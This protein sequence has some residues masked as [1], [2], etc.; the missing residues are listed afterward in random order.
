MW[1]RRLLMLSLLVRKRPLLL[2]EV[3]LALLCRVGL[4]AVISFVLSVRHPWQL[5]SCRA[6]VCAFVA[7]G[8]ESALP[9][10]KQQKLRSLACRQGLCV[11]CVY[12]I[13]LWA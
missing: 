1:Q 11:C 4:H 13:H 5:G 8:W 6:V 7:N 3:L 10:C 12:V 9:P 2:V